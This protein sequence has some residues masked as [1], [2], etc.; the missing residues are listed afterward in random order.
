MLVWYLGEI[1][2]SIESLL[3]IFW[4]GFLFLRK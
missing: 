3:D 4:Q 2:T 1:D